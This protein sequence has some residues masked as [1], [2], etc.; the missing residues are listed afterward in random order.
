[1][2]LS[3]ARSITHVPLLTIGSKSIQPKITI[4]TP[5]STWNM[6]RVTELDA[7]GSKDHILALSYNRNWTQVGDNFSTAAID[8][9][10]VQY[11]WQ[12]EH[13]FNNAGEVNWDLAPANSNAYVR[14]FGLLYTYTTQQTQ[15]G[16][17]INVASGAGG[18]SMYGGMPFGQIAVKM[19]ATQGVSPAFNLL[20]P[21]G[22]CM[23]KMRPDAG[24]IVMSG[25]TADTDINGT[26]WGASI[27]ILNTYGGVL[28]GCTNSISTA[29]AAMIG[30]ETSTDANPRWRV[31]ATGEMQWGAG[32]AAQDTNLYRSAANVLKTD[33]RFIPTAG[34]TINGDVAN[35]LIIAKDSVPVTPPGA[36]NLSLRVEVG[37]NPGTLKIVAYAGTSSSGVVIADN[38]GSGN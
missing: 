12:F 4:P 35:P 21:S 34:L 25:S 29:Y 20:R 9:S 15:V 18:V 11:T 1:M 31:L 26:G 38:I 19:T 17:G 36:G 28:V 23:M 30:N 37:T 10:Q 2:S 5:D 32:S 14:A 3:I 7:G 16:I 27:Y 33:G 24:G 8:S 6:V 13:K 22:K